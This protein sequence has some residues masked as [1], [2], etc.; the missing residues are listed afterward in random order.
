[1]DSW[2]VLLF[3]IDATLLKTG[4]AG[5]RAL[6]RAFLGLYGVPSATGGIRPEGK[7]DPAIIRE[8]LDRNTPDL[9]PGREIP[10]V[11]DLYLAYLG[12]EVEASPGFRVMP[13]VPQLL[14][15]LSRIPRIA[16]GL[17]TGNLEKGARIKLRRAGLGSY[18][19][20]GGFGSDSE[21]RTEVVRAAIDR[22]RDRLKDEVPLRSVYVIGDTPRDILH[23]KEA[24]VR[25]VAVATGRSGL[26]ELSQYDPDYLFEDFACTGRVLEV[27][28][29]GG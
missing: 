8:M 16:L 24:G 3:D 18:F 29:D 28:R 22:A 7:T 27:F 25:T 13:G 12:E 6:D 11:L 5:L 26:E 4:N 9:D 17:A 21:N 14:E 2:K 20:F 10:R 1:M 23:G 15:E 19:S